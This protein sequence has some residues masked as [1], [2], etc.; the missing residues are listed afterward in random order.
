MRKGKWGRATAGMSRAEE[1]EALRELRALDGKKKHHTGRTL[2][3]VLAALIASGAAAFYF[4]F[5]VGSWQRIDL[6]RIVN[7]PQSGAIYDHTGAFVSRIQSSENRVS[8]PLSQVP[9]DVQSAFLAAEDLRF[10]QHR[11]FD[12]IRIAGA[13]V[14]NLRSGEYGPT[15]RVLSCDRVLDAEVGGVWASDHFG[16]VADLGIPDHAPGAWAPVVA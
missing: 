3:I 2:L 5:D 1:N 10:Y 13:V 7:V 14:S 12:P 15:L 8:I 4:L 9:R 11:G 6:N 16:V